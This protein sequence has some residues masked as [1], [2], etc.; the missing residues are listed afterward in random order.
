MRDIYCQR[1][2]VALV[3]LIPF[4][5]CACLQQ[6][7]VQRIVDGDT[8]QLSDGRM[9][10]LIGLDTPEKFKSKKLERDLQ[11]TGQSHAEVVAQGVAAS[12]H[13]KNLLADPHVILK[14]DRQRID[15]YGRLLAYVRLKSGIMLNEQI[16]RDG[17]GCAYAR[18][19]FR[20][21]DEFLALER[22]AQ[23]A[24]RGLWPELRCVH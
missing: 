23:Q 1:V 9:V 4:L 24:R 22:D 17:F 2:R 18:F 5:L 13:T 12:M 21:R 19:E 8:L 10:R 16:I 6:A 14:Y 3:L 15:K 11:K 20:Y 7:V